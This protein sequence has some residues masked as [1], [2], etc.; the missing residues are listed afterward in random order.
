MREGSGVFYRYLGKHLPV[1]RNTGFLKTVNK[2]AVSQPLFARGGVEPYYPHL[3]K[4]AF[5][6]FPV[7]IGGSKGFLDLLGSHP[8]TVLFISVITFSQLKNPFLPL[9]SR[10][11]VFYSHK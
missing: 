4:I 6:V 1:E 11:A 5:P 3:A 8:E 10:Y 7:G 2:S 9:I